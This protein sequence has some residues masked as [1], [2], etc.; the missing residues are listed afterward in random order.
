MPQCSDSKG[1]WLKTDQGKVCC[2]GSIQNQIL[3]QEDVRKK[4]RYSSEL[5]NSKPLS[6]Y[7]LAWCFSLSLIRREPWWRLNWVDEYLANFQSGTPQTR[8]T[9]VIHLLRSHRAALLFLELFTMKVLLQWVVIWAWSPNFWMVLMPCR[10]PLRDG[11]SLIL[12]ISRK[13]STRLR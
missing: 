12:S 10:I 7:F 5:K 2:G 3:C 9:S 4:Y 8:Q 1:G 13:S 11:H 6:A